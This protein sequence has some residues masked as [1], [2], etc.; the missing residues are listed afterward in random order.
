[1]WRNSVG[2]PEVMSF[3]TLLRKNMSR[4]L[5]VVCFEWYQRYLWS[6]AAASAVPPVAI[7]GHCFAGHCFWSL[8]SCLLTGDLPS[9]KLSHNYGKIHYF[10]LCLMC[11]STIS[12][13]IC[14]I[15]FWCVLYVYQ[16]LLKVH[17]SLEEPNGSTFKTLFARWSTTTRPGYD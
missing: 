1:M 15:V 17:R 3:S 2:R 9:G 12:M 8:T 13:A 10:Y 4:V 14:S 5:S 11:K 7:S 16:R 6:L